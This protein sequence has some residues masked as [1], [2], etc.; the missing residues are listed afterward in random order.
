V[1]VN[2][3]ETYDISKEYDIKDMLGFGTYSQVK[4]AKCMKTGKE[5]AVKICR[6]TTSI[7][8]LKQE[9]DIMNMLDCDFFPKVIDFK[10]DKLWKRAYLIMEH[11]KGETLETFL[12]K[13]PVCSKNVTNFI[14]EL[15]RMILYLHNKGICHRD[16]KPQNIIVTK[17][18]CLKLIDFNISKVWK[19][20]A[21]AKFEKTFITQLSTPIYAAP[22][23]KLGKG[24]TQSVDVWGIGVIGYLLLG[25]VIDSESYSSNSDRSKLFQ[26][27]VD[28][29]V[30]ISDDLKVFLC[31]CLQ[32]DP[33]NRLSTTSDEFES[34]LTT[35][36]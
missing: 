36:K 19:T 21:N 6:G 25:G 35:L 12:S 29:S 1:L 27:H 15:S 24:Y 5:V 2:R 17:K 31:G 30:N 34:L 4:L 16:I 8:M 11:I 18:G 23:I 28:T 32:E 26:E 9:R 20:D 13:N 7:N 22:E 33:E 10:E 14:I 3:D